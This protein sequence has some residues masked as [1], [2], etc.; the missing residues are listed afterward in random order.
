MPKRGP[1]PKYGEAV[2]EIVKIKMTPGQRAQLLKMARVNLV[3]LTEFCRDAINDR[4]AD[5]SDELVF[6]SRQTSA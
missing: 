4:V 2:T 5:C 6:P 3:T 1:K